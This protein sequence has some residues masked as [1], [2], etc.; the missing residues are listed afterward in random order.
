[1]R[2][3]FGIDTFKSS[4]L[5]RRVAAIVENP[6]Y[7]RDMVT[8]CRN[9]FPAVQAIGKALIPLGPE[10]VENQAKKTIGR[11]VKEILSEHDWVPD[12]PGRVAPGNL[13][14]F[15]TGMLYKRRTS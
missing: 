9:E 2:N 7:V 13:F 12:K 3:S 6:E 10:V 5:G 1:M 15:S 4:P 11:W 14:S 8:F